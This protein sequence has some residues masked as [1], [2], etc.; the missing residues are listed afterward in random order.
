MLEVTKVLPSGEAVL[1][2]A[3]VLTGLIAFK[4]E[5]VVLLAEED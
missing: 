1:R 2:R 5:V 4:I 3:L